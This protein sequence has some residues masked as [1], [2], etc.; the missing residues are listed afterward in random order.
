[1]FRA[2]LCGIV[3]LTI[4]VGCHSKPA[5][6]EQ[7]SRGSR[8]R[9]TVVSVDPAAGTLTVKVRGGKNADAVEKTFQVEDDTTITSFVGEAKNEMVGKTGLGDPQFKEGSQVSLTIG[10]DGGK[11]RSIQVGDLPRRGRNRGNKGGK[12]PQQ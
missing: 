3:S 4:A 7:K 1:M 6:S 11:V 10:E 8:A 5:S 12:E 2:I 9:G